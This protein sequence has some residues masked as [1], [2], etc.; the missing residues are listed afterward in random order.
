M[1]GNTYLYTLF[2][3]GKGSWAINPINAV[4]DIWLTIL[5]SQTQE[6]ILTI[7]FS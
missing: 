2:S 3:I 6:N 4:P 5:K 1:S 7:F